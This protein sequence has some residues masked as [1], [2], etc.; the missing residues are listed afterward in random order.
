MSE[1]K[2]SLNEVATDL[3]IAVVNKAV[4]ER[5]TDGQGNSEITIAYLAAEAAKAYKVIFQAMRSPLD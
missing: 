5:K 3:T 4:L 1:T 2:K